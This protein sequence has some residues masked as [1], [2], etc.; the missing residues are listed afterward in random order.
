MQGT[1]IGEILLD[2]IGTK[3]SSRNQP[4]QSPGVFLSENCD[5][6][7]ENEKG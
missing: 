5:D 3:D 2:K 6:V 7:R 4:L 1:S